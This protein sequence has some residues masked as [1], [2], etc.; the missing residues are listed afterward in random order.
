MTKSEDIND[1]IKALAIYNFLNEFNKLESMIKNKFY[2][3]VNE[4]NDSEKNMLYF[5]HG[6]LAGKVIVNYDVET[7]NYNEMKFKKNEEFKHFTLNQIIKLLE[8]SS[9]KAYFPD[10]MKMMNYCIHRIGFFGSIKRFISMRNKLAHKV[11]DLDFK[12][13][14]FIELLSIQTIEEKLKL[15]IN[16]NYVEAYQ[17][18][19]ICSNLVYINMYKE[20][21]ENFWRVKTDDNSE[22]KN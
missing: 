4:V 14:D 15:K 20:Y 10:D 18:Q 13:G 16:E 2:Q 11:S 6:G 3:L 21:V 12:S 9:L 1:S 19:I 22:T 5:F 8:N 17:I 7:L